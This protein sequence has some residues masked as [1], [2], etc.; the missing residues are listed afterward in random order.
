MSEPEDTPSHW[1]RDL[2]IGAAVVLAVVQTVRMSGSE[3]EIT[4]LH[5]ELN[6]IQRVHVVSKTPLLRAQLV[7][8]QGAEVLVHLIPLRSA[9]VDIAFFDS[10]GHE[11]AACSHTQVSL[12]PELR[13]T[14]PGGEL[15]VSIIERDP[16]D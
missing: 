10:A 1:V 3:S 2:L 15:D 9:K 13:C 12:A 6:A 14:A 11:I 5:Q 16:H 8:R 4:R 7:E